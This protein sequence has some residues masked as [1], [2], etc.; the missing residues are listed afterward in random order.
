M[1]TLALLICAATG[2]PL[3]GLAFSL[4]A[5]YV[6]RG[7]HPVKQHPVALLLNVVPVA[8]L[9]AIFISLP[10]ELALDVGSRL[11]LIK[12]LF[13]VSSIDCP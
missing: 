11:S 5:S 4:C 12:C 2:F 10:I 13:S 9:G 1:D 6:L 7:R 3:I 8:V